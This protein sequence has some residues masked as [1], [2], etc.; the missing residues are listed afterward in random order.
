MLAGV[1]V[2]LIVQVAPAASV[3]GD[4]GQAFEGGAVTAN[5]A[6]SAPPSAILLIVSAAVPL[7]VSVSA[8]TALIVVTPWSLNATL[9][10]DSVTAATP[11]VP[12]PLSATAAGLPVALWATDRLALFAP[13]LAGVKLRMIEQL[14]PAASVAGA[15]GHTPAADA[16]IANC[17]AST[18]PIDTPLI[19]SAAVPLLVSVSVRVLLVVETPWSPKPTLLADSLTAATPPVPVPLSARLVVPAL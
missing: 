9:V 13:L 17:A 18:P 3:P 16:A 19:V 2:T 12:V 4:T 10:A 1:N 8:R 5:C 6:A 15:T 11:P 7:L 14:A